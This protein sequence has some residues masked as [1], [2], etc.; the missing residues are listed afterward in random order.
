MFQGKIVGGICEDAKPDASDFI[1]LSGPR[2]PLGNSGYSG[3]CKVVIFV[4][5]MVIGGKSEVYCTLASMC[6]TR[7]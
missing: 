6:V 1:E 2:K 3:T 5:V 4:I 7:G